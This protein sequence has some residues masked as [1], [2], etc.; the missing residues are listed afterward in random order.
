M[1][2]ANQFSQISFHF[3]INCLW[4]QILTA[5]K[6]FPFLLC[7]R[8]I[9]LNEIVCFAQVRLQHINMFWRD[10][11]KLVIYKPPNYKVY[12]LLKKYDNQKK[13]IPIKKYQWQKCVSIIHMSQ[14]NNQKNMFQE[15]LVFFFWIVPH[16][17]SH[18]HL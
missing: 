17:S 8:E 16:L 12:V 10:Q 1:N 11:I 3:T 9:T 13:N 7:A 5:F 15:I 6:F 14:L 18:S 2:V 4:K